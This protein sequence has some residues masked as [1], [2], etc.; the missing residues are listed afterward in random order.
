MMRAALYIIQESRLNSVEN[1]LIGHYT[2]YYSEV[3]TVFQ[4]SKL[5]I[6]IISYSNQIVHGNE[7]N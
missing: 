1:E 2:I 3:F 7:V 5:W 4:Q 6:V